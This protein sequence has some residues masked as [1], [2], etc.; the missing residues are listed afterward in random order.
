LTIAGDPRSIGGELRKIPLLVALALTV[1]IVLVELGSPLIMGSGDDPPGRGIPYLALVDIVLAYTILLVSLPIVVPD[2]LQG[3]IQGIVT[4]VGAIVLL[5]VAFLLTLL[6]LAALL[7][8]VS[9]FLAV[10]FGTIAY[11]AAFGDFATGE[12]AAILSLLMMLKLAFCV[13]LV[14][15]Q[16]RF[17]QNKGLVLLVVTSLVATIIVAFLHGLV[18]GPLVSITDSLAAIVV[19]ILAIIWAIVLLIGSIPAILRAIKSS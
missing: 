7:L 5:I 18:P 17:L 12:A 1:V 15:A 16:Q 10:P 13:F 9:L 19:G 2:H 8:M 6:A 14:I 3:K 4:F 11:L